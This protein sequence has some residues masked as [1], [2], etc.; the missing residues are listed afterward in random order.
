ML[1]ETDGR[2]DPQDPVEF[3][4]FSDTY[5]DDP[6]EMYR[7]LRDEAPVYHSERYGFYALSRYD[8]VS[9]AHKDWHTFS[10]TH[11]VDVYTLSRDPAEIATFR[12][13]IMMDPPEHDRFR[14]LVS[15]VFTPRAVT[16][17]EPMIREVVTGFL[18]SLHHTIEK[19]RDAC[20]RFPATVWRRHTLL[21]RNEH[22]QER[23]INPQADFNG[24][25]LRP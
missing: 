20:L 17:L 3:D 9:E 10:S 7:R 21:G 14:A 13:I 15:R 11:G 23:S 24:G 22:H 18:A 12:S 2:Q 19:C 25:P 8:D 16:A 4:P 1:I 6:Y 5:F